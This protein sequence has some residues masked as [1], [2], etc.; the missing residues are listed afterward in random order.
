MLPWVRFILFVMSTCL[1]LANLYSFDVLGV[2]NF[3]TPEGFVV[4]D[5]SYSL[6][7][8]IDVSLFVFRIACNVVV[9]MKLIQYPSD[10][11]EEGEHGERKAEHLYQIIENNSYVW[12]TLHAFALMVVGTTNSTDLMLDLFSKRIMTSI[13]DIKME[14]NVQILDNVT[15]NTL[16]D[17]FRVFF[18]VSKIIFTFQGLIYFIINM[19]RPGTYTFKFPGI[20]GTI[21]FFFEIIVFFTGFVTTVMF[22]AGL[23]PHSVQQKHL[24][25]GNSEFLESRKLEFSF[26]ILNELVLIVACHLLVIFYYF[27]PSKMY[28]DDES[29]TLSRKNSLVFSFPFRAVMIGYY[30]SVSSCWQILGFRYIKLYPDLSDVAVLSP[31]IIYSISLVFVSTSTIVMVVEQGRHGMSVVQKEVGSFVQQ[32][33]MKIGHNSPKI[34]LWKLGIVLGLLSLFIVIICMNAGWY[35]IKMFPGTVPREVSHVII[36][37]TDE[38]EDVGHKAFDAMKKLDPCRWDPSKGPDQPQTQS[39]TSNTAEWSFSFVDQSGQPIS[40]TE[41]TSKLDLKHYSLNTYSDFATNQNHCKSTG[42]TCNNLA[43]HV[44]HL[45]NARKAFEDHAQSDV[46]ADLYNHADFNTFND[47]DTEYQKELT[48]CHNDWCQNVLLTAVGIE[49]LMSAGD[50]FGFLPVIG[51]IGED[52]VEWTAWFSQIAN[53]ASDGVVKFGKTVY[54]FVRELKKTLGFIGPMFE[55]V[56]KLVRITE[57]YVVA[58]DASSFIIYVPSLVFGG[59]CFLLGFWKRVNVKSA[60]KDLDNLVMFFIPLFLANLMMIVLM[61]VFPYIITELLKAMPEAIIKVLFDM[62]HAMRLVRM[63]FILSTLGVSF[64]VASIVLDV[65]EKLLPNFKRM[66]RGV[67]SFFRRTFTRQRGGYKMGTNA[68]VENG[69]LVEKWIDVDWLQAFVINIPVIIFL[70]III[71]DNLEFV[72]F[73]F[74]PSSDMIKIVQGFDSH[75]HILAHSKR[76]NDDI[77]AFTCG[78]VGEAIKELINFAI[79]ILQDGVVSVADKLEKF[80]VSVTVFQEL[81][82][83]IEDAGHFLLD[84][85]GETWHLAEKFLAMAVPVINTFLFLVGSLVAGRQKYLEKNKRAEESVDMEMIVNIINRTITVLALYNITIILMVQQTFAT[86]KH[87]NLFLFVFEAKVGVLSTYAL[88][89]SGLNLLG[90]FSLYISSM[91]NLA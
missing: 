83:T 71:R 67:K 28:D 66:K 5:E 25:I 14:G 39:T 73:T 2:N 16:H 44:E 84:V 34:I 76:T 27:Y 38:I 3:L 62:K 77:D 54:W 60:T 18:L 69:G 68:L 10:G 89:S 56:L 19:S 15:T 91:Y 64:F 11:I 63:S 74:T 46:L 61:Y 65:Y 9:M 17:F 59:L 90:V 40:G 6:H 51:L 57:K 43:K 21:M 13:H 36:K 88:I 52:A 8:F 78:I 37:L 87:I 58:P 31:L 50:V 29:K 75:A 4:K 81:L 53:R 55:K 49:A 80:L 12:D 70:V 30:T 42:A 79:D 32:L 82:S 24:K 45:R 1:F 23:N 47:S 35:E 72:K 85:M 33:G 48:K 20:R 26:E 86:I 7:F 41:Y 22:V